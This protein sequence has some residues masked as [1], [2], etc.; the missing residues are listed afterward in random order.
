MAN[1]VADYAA[2]QMRYWCVTEDHGG[3]GYSQPNRW[4]AYERSDWAG[5]LLAPGEMDCS[6]GVGGSYNIAFHEV[7][8]EQVRPEMFL[9][10]LWTGSLR[11]ECLARG[12]ADIG[13]SWTGNAPAGGFA[14][15]DLLLKDGH[16]AMAVFEE[17]GTFIPDNPALAEAWI[18]RTGDIMGAAGDDGSPHDDTDGETRVIRYSDHPATQA[19]T[20]STCLRYT[21]GAP[22][23]PPST[24]GSQA[25]PSAALTWGVDISMHQ[26]Y[27]QVPADAECVIIKASEG[28][29]YE[30]PKWRSHAQKAWDQGKAVGL[31]HFARPDLGNTAEEEAAW[32]LRT[33][34]GWLGYAVLVLD[35][36]REP[37]GDVGWAR[38]FLDAVWHGA[39]TRPWIYM[40][41]STASGH[42]WEPVAQY[43]PLWMAS[44]DGRAWDDRSGPHPGHG[45]QLIGKQYTEDPIDKDTFYF[46]LPAWAAAVKGRDWPT[47]TN[48]EEQ[49]LMAIKDEIIGT[50][51]SPIWDKAVE[52]KTEVLDLKARVSTLEDVT[53]KGSNLDGTWRPGILQI[54]IENQKRINALTKEVAELKAAGNGKQE[55]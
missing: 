13:D 15:G 23:T 20:W 26:D 11:A 46:P 14:P 29:G 36:E 31:Y 28:V 1:P 10:S 33:V 16:V 7:L 12:F 51:L 32:F 34:R 47:T 42:A 5:W 22:S 30:D 6:S 52:I 19:A 4:T 21:G 49:E 53:H 54:V 9:R 39:P 35:W 55:G 2:R 27:G 50:W 38:R 45:W 41:L 8:A 17:D 18:D 43:Y 37:L 3:V 44:Y 24:G 25:E 48:T 40:N